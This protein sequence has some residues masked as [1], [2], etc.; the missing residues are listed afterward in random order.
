M[1]NTAHF[2]IPVLDQLTKYLEHNPWEAS[3]HS[4]SQE[5]PAF[6]KTQRFITVF[7]GSY[8]EPDESS[9]HL[10]TSFP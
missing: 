7:T 3:S 2:H 1:N 6:Y 5:I 10:P 8:P 9:P 4:T